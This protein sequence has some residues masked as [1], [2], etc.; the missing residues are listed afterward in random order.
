MEKKRRAFQAEGTAE[1]KALRQEMAGALTRLY[2]MSCEMMQIRGCS[3]RS[4]ILLIFAS[5]AFP[6]GSEGP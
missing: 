1:A 5:G 4:L 3:H 2:G 6:E